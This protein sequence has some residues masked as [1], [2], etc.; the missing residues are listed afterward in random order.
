MDYFNKNHTIRLIQF[1]N[2]SFFEVYGYILSFILIN[3]MKLSALRKKCFSINSYPYNKHKI[4]RIKSDKKQ[5]IDLFKINE[6][7]SVLCF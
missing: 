7:K 4:I 2:S 3:C 6:V 5:S 1:M